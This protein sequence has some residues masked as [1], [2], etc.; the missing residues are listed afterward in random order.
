MCYTVESIDDVRNLVLATRGLSGLADLPG[1]LAKA[2][3]RMHALIGADLAAIAIYDG[4]DALV[5]GAAEGA[6][7]DL[8]GITLPRSSSLGWR[9]LERSMPVT[10]G[11]C[12][13]DPDSTD[14]LVDAII[15]DDIRGLAAVP[16]E[17][18]GNWLGVMYAGMRGRRVS[19]R[20][21]L[22]MNEFGASLAPLIVTAARAGREGRL[23]VEEERQRIAQQLHDTAGQIL[24]KIAMSAQQLQQ[25]P[26]A[27]P[28]VVARSARE[29]EADAAEASA[30]LREAMHN[31]MPTA[32]A[33][34]VTIRRDAT[35]FATRTG[36]AIEVVT[37]GTPAPAKAEIEGVLLSVVREALHN[38]EKHAGASAVFVS[39]AYQARE[40]ALAVSDDGKGLPVDFELNAVPGRR[41]GL[42]IPGMLQK[43]QGVGG[44]L[45]LEANDDGGT[46]LRVVIPIEAAA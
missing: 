39:V 31:L 15:G 4:A 26:Q 14:D 29:I 2:C 37:L 43:V 6:I 22:L 11:N 45:R 9:A 41:S 5:I 44:T 32:D 30:Y 19:P 7:G 35:M 40:I 3:K 36:N 28:E 42:G 12:A 20:V 38:I 23:A 46:S 33:L 10:T 24:F 16:I 25:T 34:P 8:V 18:G 21:T 13:A 27:D 1:L 17:F